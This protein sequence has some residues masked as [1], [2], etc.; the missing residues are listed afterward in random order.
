MD[1]RASRMASR[2]GCFGS[3]R[4]ERSGLSARLRIAG[5][6]GRV[7]R[8]VGVSGQCE[9]AGRRGTPGLVV[10][11]RVESGGTLL[12]H[13]GDPGEGRGVLVVRADRGAS[14]GRA[15]EFLHRPGLC[16]GVVRKIRMA[17]RIHS[18]R[19]LGA[20][21][22]GAAVCT[23]RLPVE[24]IRQRLG[25]PR[26]AGGCVH[27]TRRLGRRARPDASHRPVGLRSGAWVGVAWGSC[28]GGGGL[29][30]TGSVAC[31][32][33]GGAA[34][35]TLIRRAGSGRRGRRREMEPGLRPRHLP[36]GT[37]A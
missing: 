37:C 32:L 18:G 24:P 6:A 26:Q 22:H 8:P 31:G 19:R 11:L 2:P 33:A 21:R 36:A 27:P 14:A 13:R 28:C 7:S 20:V 35:Q 17:S 9:R 5:A 15:A 10:R 16:A 1:R 29:G 25:V 34:D 12:G 30:R 23:W 4:A 3:G